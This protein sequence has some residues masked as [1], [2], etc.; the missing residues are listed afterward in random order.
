MRH[1]SPNHVNRK[2]HYRVSYQVSKNACP[3]HA[4]SYWTMAPPSGLTHLNITF[5]KWILNLIA[6]TIK[7][8]FLCIVILQY[9]HLILYSHTRCDSVL[10]R[11]QYW[12]ISR[13]RV[14]TNCDFNAVLNGP[15]PF[16]ICHSEPFRVYNGME[17]IKCI[18]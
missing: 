12:L 1:Y 16:S 18:Q 3:C 13:Q 17:R 15:F 2:A 5:K 7:V 10:G 14:H 9:A 4:M 6:Y 8:V 11:T